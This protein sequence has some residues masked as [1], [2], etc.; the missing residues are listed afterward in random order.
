MASTDDLILRDAALAA[1]TN[2]IVISDAAEGADGALLYVNRGFERVTGYRSEEVL[3][4]NCR[5]LQGPGTDPAAVRELGDAVRECRATTVTLLN[6][7][8]DGRPFWNE[9]SLS[10]VSDGQR[11]THMIGVQTDVTQRHQAEE[12]VAFLAYHDAL[13]GLANRAKVEERLAAALEHAGR[14]GREVALLFLDLDDFKGVND[15]FGHAAGDELLR[16]VTE[17]LDAVVRPGDLLARQGGDEFLLVLADVADGAAARGAEVAARLEEAL[18]PGFLIA[19]ESVVVASSIG[20]STFPDDAPDPDTLLQHADA[21]MY[22]AKAAGGGHH[23]YGQGRA[24]GVSSLPTAAPEVPEAVA[25]RELD[26]I[27]RDGLIR[28][29]YQPIVDLETREVCAYE[30]LARG[31]VDSPLERPDLLFGT[32]ARVGRLVELDWACGRAAVAGA[33][34][35]G[36]RR[37]LKLFVNIEPST[38]GT[39]P[40]TEEL[41]LADPALRD[42]DV[43][44]ELTERAL[45]E[46]PGRVLAGVERI[47]DRGWGVALDDVGAERRSLAFMP[48][49]RPDVIKLDLRLVQSNP[50]PE[51]AAI[52]H[53]VNADA[54][55]SGAVVL[56]EGIEDEDQLRVGR[57]LGATHGQGWLFGRPGPLPQALPEPRRPLPMRTTLEAGDRDLTPFELVAERLDV[58]RG[59]KRLLLAISKHLEAQVAAHPDAAVLVSTF[60]EAR[61]FTDATRGRYRRLA[62]SAAFVGTLGVGLAAEPIAG[63][64]GASLHVAEPL[65][66]E[67]NVVVVTPHFAAAFVGRDLGD[68]GADMERRFDF[69]LTYDR[70]LAV[71]AADALMRRIAPS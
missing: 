16:Q 14:T 56:A 6:Y 15:R 11:V 4:R 19:G 32:A 13:T 38:L 48:F 65:R 62:Q 17:R 43:V 59:P 23:V 50:T 8:A 54:E 49:V 52:V 18:A 3:G 37:P 31:P 51:I 70:D 34:A 7:R 39:A 68:D 21:A 9:V 69:C 61:H 57:A 20:V 2:G 44:V 55:R 25:E 24:R 66:A 22:A 28:S 53:A 36:L 27:L 45:G 10:P 33:V 71:R 40:P 29:V 46:R 26:R 64:R 58:R 47:R 30:A 42:L 41:S 5:I 60:Q 1:A 63:V 12:Q 67:W 35:A